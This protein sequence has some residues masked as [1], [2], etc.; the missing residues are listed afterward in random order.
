VLIRPDG[1]VAQASPSKSEPPP[2]AKAAMA[3]AG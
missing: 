2:Q 1:Y 3:S